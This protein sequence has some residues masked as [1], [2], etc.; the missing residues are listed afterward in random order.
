MS[1]VT[2]AFVNEGMFEKAD[3][4]FCVVAINTSE[5]DFNKSGKMLPCLRFRQNSFPS[6]LSHRL[7]FSVIE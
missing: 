4:K 7:S 1:D 6:A 5:P 2:N 3:L